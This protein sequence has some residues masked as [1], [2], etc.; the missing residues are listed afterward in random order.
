MKLSK[1]AQKVA[2]KIDE[3]FIECKE[4]IREGYL[5]SEVM[6]VVIKT[7]SDILDNWEPE[8]SYPTKCEV[9]DWVQ[10]EYGICMWV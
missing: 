7:I 6:G 9:L 2:D 8:L 1:R 10:Y 5:S 3:M 4:D